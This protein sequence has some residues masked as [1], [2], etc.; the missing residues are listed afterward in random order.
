MMVRIDD[1]LLG[2]DDGLVNER[3]PLAGTRRRRTHSPELYQ[4]SRPR[5]HPDQQARRATNRERPT[6]GNPR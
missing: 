3:A 2:V 6:P 5:E 1:A 4:A